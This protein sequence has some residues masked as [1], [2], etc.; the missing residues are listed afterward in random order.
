MAFLRAHKVIIKMSLY[1]AFCVLMASLALAWLP[2]PARTVTRQADARGNLYSGTQD[3]RSGAWIGQVEIDFKD[4]SRYV[5]SLDGDDL[6]GYGTF[7]SAKGHS[8]SGRFIDG[9]PAEEAVT[10]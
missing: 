4:G 8:I 6:S 3:A 2:L 7:T 5:G 10:P 9:E 1:L